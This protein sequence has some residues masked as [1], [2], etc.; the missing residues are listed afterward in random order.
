M[1]VNEYDASMPP[2]IA[3]IRPVPGSFDRA[4]VR[5]GQPDLDVAVARAQHDVYR[6]HLTDAGYSIEVVPSDESHPDCVFIEDTAVIIGSVAVITRPGA[7]AR[8]GETGPVAGVLS[9]YFPLVEIEKP[10]TID[11]G[12]VFTAGGVVYVGR[13]TRTNDA[14]IGQLRSVVSDQGLDLIVVDVHDTLHLKSAVLPIDPETMVVTPHAV[15]EAPLAG[16]N[17]VYEADS[18]RHRFSAVPLRD[19]RVLSTASSPATSEKVAALGYQLVPIDVSEIQ[20]ADG[21]LTCMSILF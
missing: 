11:G 2:S 5:D 14:G 10:A 8:R 7:L 19:G 9:A 13:S 17:I 6:N 1:K 18:E 20:A 4:L 12:D 16:L 21:G 3:L 15:D